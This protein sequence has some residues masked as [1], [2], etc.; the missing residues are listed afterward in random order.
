MVPPSEPALGPPFELTILDQASL[1]VFRPPVATIGGWG[2][3]HAV[4]LEGPAVSVDASKVDDRDSRHDRS[5][6]RRR[7]T[8]KDALLVANRAKLS[9][10]LERLAVTGDEIALSELRLDPAQESF[11]ISGQAIVTNVMATFSVRVAIRKAPQ[12]PRH[13]QL[14]F[15]DVRL[16]GYLPLPGSRIGLALAEG[17]ANELAIATPAFVCAR[18]PYVEIDLLEVALLQTFVVRGWRLPGIQGTRLATAGWVGRQFQLHFSGAAASGPLSPPRPTPL[19]DAA[20]TEADCL[21]VLGESPDHKAAQQHLLGLRVAAD[22][23]GALS[24]ANDLLAKDPEDLVVT[25]LAGIAATKAEDEGRAIAL[26]EAAAALADHYDENGDAVRARAA[27]EAIKAKSAPARMEETAVD[28]ASV[29]G[30]SLAGSSLAEA[31]L[32]DESRP[33]EANQILHEESAPQP[34]APG[35]AD[36]I[37]AKTLVVY[38]ADQS[39]EARATALNQLLRRLRTLPEEQAQA[40]FASFARVAER[41]GDLEHAEEAYWQATRVGGD[42]SRRADDL[43]ALARVLL[44]RGNDAG[45]TVELDRALAIS[46]EHVGALTLAADQAFR[47]EQHQ[48]A[49]EMYERLAS[50]PSFSD[51]IDRDTL[52]FRRGILA[53]GRG[54]TALGRA[55]L[56]ELVTLNPDH[57]KAHQALGEI[58]EEAKDFATA[59]VHQENV[60]RLLPPTALETQLDTHQTL[61]NLHTALSDWATSQGFVEKV[62]ARDPVRIPMLERLAE[63]HEQE[64]RPAEAADVCARLAQIY[65]S[66]RQR[67][68]VLFREAELRREFL[69]DEDGAMA[70]YLKSSDLDPTFPP[71]ALR[72]LTE[73]WRSG[74]LGD[75]AG[76]GEDFRRAPEAWKRMD[77]KLRLRLAVAVMLARKD[78]KRA[79]DTADLGALPWRDDSADAAATVLAEIGATWVKRSP[80]DLDPVFTLISTWANATSADSPVSFQTVL[81]NRFSQ[82]VTEAGV[83]RALGCWAEQQGNAPLARVYYAAAVFLDREDASQAR[84]DELGPQ[85]FTPA[86]K[87]APAPSEI[88]GLES[89]D[90][91]SVL[92]SGDVLATLE[93]QISKDPMYGPEVE[94]L[95]ESERRICFLGMPRITALFAYL[96]S[97]DYVALARTGT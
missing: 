3:F 24:D 94:E 91:Q 90:Q 80:R 37:T 13:A 20:S 71:T 50:H 1:L 4:D 57:R 87:A 15:G 38:D 33:V 72:L 95:S 10:A 12:H 79:L 53:R 61:A 93:Q 6:S 78:V 27:A 96:T 86:A 42:L 40:A 45:A 51:V 52:W 63:I 2:E 70:A 60:L 44:S 56:T 77:A 58:A 81:Q 46:P 21:R 8:L 49:A 14:D 73:F 16:F 59:I 30:E 54:D 31:R 65:P 84:L 55:L 19:I 89:S 34:F 7:L 25:L 41:S 62:L 43:V 48:R 29:V 36:N 22:P 69:G 47:T 97:P 83:A 75:M 67:A 74:E 28:D 32:G 66:P 92:A 76:V 64:G 68:E 23:V 26:F 11:V 9:E 88:E 17:V 5:F 35:E 85:D 18:G 82:D 39:P